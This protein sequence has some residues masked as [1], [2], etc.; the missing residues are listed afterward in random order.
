MTNIVFIIIAGT[1][2]LLTAI[3]A[4]VLFKRV[5]DEHCLVVLFASEFLFLPSTGTQLEIKHLIILFTTS[6]I[7]LRRVRLRAL[8][9]EKFWFAL[10]FLI[11]FGM[12]LFWFLKTGML[13]NLITG[14]TNTTTGNFTVYLNFFCNACLFACG[15]NARVSRRFWL[16]LF[17]L[18][19]FVV[20]IQVFAMTLNSFGLLPRIPIIMPAGNDHVIVSAFSDFKRNGILSQYLYIETL[21]LIVVHRRIR[22]PLTVI[23]FMT[24]L[25][26][27]GGRTEVA[28]ILMVVILVEMMEARSAL[29]LGIKLSTFGICLFLSVWLGLSYMT[30]GQKSRFSEITDT[31]NSAEMT[32]ETSGRMAMWLYS[33]EGFRKSP[34]FGN[35]VS[36]ENSVTRRV[37]A[38]ERNV[39]LGSS[40]Q[41]YLSVLYTFGLAGFISIVSG[42][43]N[44]M[45]RLMKFWRVDETGIAGVLL[46]TLL[47]HTTGLLMLNCGIKTLL[48][49]FFLFLGAVPNISRD[50][51]SKIVV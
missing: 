7:L 35:G 8:R 25:L 15:L 30:E 29:S 48:F 14:N 39:R 9:K 21:L 11:Y 37:T 42:L 49:L 45:V 26:V 34:I 16:R 38:A 32:S 12:G 5:K 17:K 51:N 40:H 27:G 41:F 19:A 47:S 23:M 1:F 36:Q 13:P 3:F 46:I 2:L 43:L 50:I 24:N 18:F 22:L 6:L 4:N 20:G 10:P 33:M 44:A 28:S 31:R